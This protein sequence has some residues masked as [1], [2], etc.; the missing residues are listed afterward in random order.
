M[1]K[2]TFNDEYGELFVGSARE[3]KSLYKNLE[4]KTNAFPRFVEEPI[5]RKDQMYGIHVQEDGQYM[6]LNASSCLAA[7]LN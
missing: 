2:F 7:I 4:R 5:L 3:I 1:K 6:V